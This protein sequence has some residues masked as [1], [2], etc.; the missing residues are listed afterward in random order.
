MRERRYRAFQR[1]ARVLH[2]ACGFL[3][4]VFAL[5]FLL[6]EQSD[7]LMLSYGMFSVSDTPF[8]LLRASIISVVCLVIPAQ[9]LYSLVSLPLS[10]KAL[11]WSPSYILLGMLTSLFVLDGVSSWKMCMEI[12]ICFIFFF[13][14]FFFRSRPDFH[15]H[16]RPRMM[17][18]YASNLTVTLI[19]I[20]ACWTLS[21]TSIPLHYSIETAR[22]V[23]EGRMEEVMSS[24]E[25][26]DCL[27]NR[28]LRSDDPVGRSLKV[29]HYL[30]R[31][32]GYAPH[33]WSV[34]MSAFVREAIAVEERRDT[35]NSYPGER[36][37]RLRDFKAA[38]PQSSSINNNKK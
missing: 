18:L 16:S 12:L 9:L 10:V 35:V 25:R 30:G 29:S 38:L 24:P 4:V 19:S 2:G 33:D 23:R 17:S 6:V 36:L 15:R 7:V 28:L 1:T 27:V 14:F 3:F 34:P 5:H 32:L 8:D 37:Y 21:N 26:M 20:F 31:W 22:M 13:F 11:V